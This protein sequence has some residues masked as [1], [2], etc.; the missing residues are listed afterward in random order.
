MSNGVIIISSCRITDTLYNIKKSLEE[1]TICS[2]RKMFA[3]IYCDDGEKEATKKRVYIW[4]KWT[5]TNASWMFTSRL[6]HHLEEP[7]FEFDRWDQPIVTKRDEYGNPTQHAH[8]IVK[9]SS[10]ENFKKDE[11][12]FGSRHNEEIWSRYLA[13][14]EVIDDTDDEQNQDD[15]QDQDEEQEQD[16]DE[17][18]DQNKN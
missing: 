2:V 9:P 5:N 10:R 13:Q 4:V 14:G 15:E 6:N 7:L 11:E 12:V 18:Q 16:Q 3:V 17:E 8:W 1:P